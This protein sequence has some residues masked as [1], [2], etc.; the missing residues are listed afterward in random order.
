MERPTQ[1]K[2]SK[3]N[4]KLLYNNDD[5]GDTCVGGI[6]IIWDSCEPT[7]WLVIFRLI[8]L[9]KTKSLKYAI[10]FISCTRAWSQFWMSVSFFPIYRR[11]IDCSFDASFSYLTMKCNKKI[12]V[13]KCIIFTLFIDVF[14][15]P[16]L[17]ILRGLFLNQ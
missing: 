17:L 8:I 2:Y 10:S 4:L 16:L 14:S 9:P 6:Q 1:Y 7:N 5:W 13:N 12:A 11:T 15:V 3:K